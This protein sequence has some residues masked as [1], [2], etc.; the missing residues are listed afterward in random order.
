MAEQLSVTYVIDKLN[1]F[2]SRL[3]EHNKVTSG[4][5]AQISAN[6]IGKCLC[7]LGVCK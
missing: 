4:E 3:L 5:Y 6:Y 1:A 7:S 2:P